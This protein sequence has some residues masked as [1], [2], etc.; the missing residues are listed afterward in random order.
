MA[1]K[2]NNMDLQS[3]TSN[4]SFSLGTSKEKASSH[5]TQQ[6]QISIETSDNASLK[7]HCQSGVSANSRSLQRQNLFVS[8]AVAQAEELHAF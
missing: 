3:G 2:V 8:T 5:E 1:R 4:L 7:Q 6:P